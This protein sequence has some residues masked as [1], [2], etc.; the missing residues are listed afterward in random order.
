MN[1]IHEIADKHVPSKYFTPIYFAVDY[2]RKM[3]QAE[4]LEMLTYIKERYPKQYKQLATIDKW[5][6]QDSLPKQEKKR[7]I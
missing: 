5:Y 2:L 6:I 1:W 7:T 4:R 3:G